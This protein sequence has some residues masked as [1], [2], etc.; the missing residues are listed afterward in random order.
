[1]LVNGVALR[2]IR[3][4]A[5]GVEI[6]DQTR[7]PASLELMELGDL[8]QV[9]EAISAMRVRGAPLIGVTAAY[10]L[11][12]GLRQDPGAIEEHCA[13]LLAS[14]PTAVNLRWA[15]DRVHKAVATLP[16]AERAERALAE[17]RLIAE[18]EV[19]ACRAIG[20]HG[21]A[22][23]KPLA[24][25]RGG[26]ALRVMTHC[27]AG[28]LATVDHGTALAPLYRLHDDG[29]K[30]HLW[31]SETRPRNQG[32]LSMWELAG[33]GVPCTLVTDS[34]CGH[35]LQRGEVDAVLVGTD[36]TTRTGDVANKIGTWPKAL[37]AREMRVP[38]YVAVPSSSI[39]WGLSDGMEIPIEHRSGEELGAGAFATHNPA[40]D[41]T[42]AR[43]VTAFITERGVCPAS[44]RGLRSLFPGR[45]R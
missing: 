33:H 29:V 25:E 3:E 10:G 44:G 36:R 20:E 18:E 32:L 21:A 39:D 23:L 12:L 13:E 19:A 9:A 27:N 5:A 30:L 7:L 37:I 31:V 38:F 40:F 43:L 26:E 22:L 17:A 4:T 16:A 14:R 2:S 24:A 28:W 15:L 35:L 42:P 8:R 34:A 11:A 45:S 1:M 41:V 6:I